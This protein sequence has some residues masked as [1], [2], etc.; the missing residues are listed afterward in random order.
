MKLW[1]H[2]DHSL[3]SQIGYKAKDLSREINKRLKVRGINRLK[4]QEI[5]EEKYKRI[6]YKYLPQKIPIK[7]RED[8]H[9]VLLFRL[10]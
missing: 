3:R 1:Q 2:I 5:Q 6:Y 9:L 7:N 10:H 8:H 4:V